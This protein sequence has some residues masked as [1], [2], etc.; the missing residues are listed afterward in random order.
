MRSK[1]SKQWLQEH[2]GDVYVNKAKKE[3]YRSRASYKLLEI[4]AKDKLFHLGMNVLD[5][6]AA[7]GGWSQ[8]AQQLVGNQGKV[9]ATDILAMDSI[10]GVQFVQGDFR[11]NYVFEEI[12]EL[13]ANAPID[14]V[15]SDMAPNMSGNRSVD[16][17]RAMYLMELALDMA[18]RVL[19]P[20]GA[21]LV[22]VFEG[23]GINEYRQQVQQY[24]SKVLIRK[25]DASRNRSRETYLLALNF[26][27]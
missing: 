26:I 1:S 4:Q 25:P 24:F 6:G 10:S 17:P 8:V 7:P 23:V 13:L 15:M 11:E 20:N 21:F 12:L 22:K 3:G 19:K 14:I 16:Q 2:H 18:C 9:I 5:L 27:A